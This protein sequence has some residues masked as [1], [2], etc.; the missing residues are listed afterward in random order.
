MARTRKTLLMTT[1]M[2]RKTTTTIIATTD[3]NK[4]GYPATSCGRVG[5]S[6]Y[7]RFPT[8]R[9]DHLYGP[10]NQRTDGRTKPLIEFHVRN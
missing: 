5:R 2:S 6:G 9:L 1:T 8:F 7:A 3:N 10:T 4:A